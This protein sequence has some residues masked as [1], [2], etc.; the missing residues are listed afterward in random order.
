L[1][2]ARRLGRRQRLVYGSL[3]LPDPASTF[4]KLRELFASGAAWP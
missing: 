1:P 2:A 3:I 4:A